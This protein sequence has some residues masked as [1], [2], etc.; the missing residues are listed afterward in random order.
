[1]KKIY[2]INFQ[3]IR[4]EVRKN[5]SLMHF[6]SFIENESQNSLRKLFWY[7]FSSRHWLIAYG[8]VW[9]ENKNFYSKEK[10]K[11]ETNT[12]K[13]QNNSQKLNKQCM[14]WTYMNTEYVEQNKKSLK[15]RN[16]F[17][18]NCTYLFRNSNVCLKEKIT[19]EFN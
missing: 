5:V 6:L 14:W 10:K 1:M 15:E 11:N 9:T 17:L 13:R 3:K 2:R 7:C 12:T 19:T 4:D 8:N 16:N 18:I